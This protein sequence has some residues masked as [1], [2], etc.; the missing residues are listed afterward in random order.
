[1]DSDFRQNDDE[2]LYS[3]AGL[4]E[5]NSGTTTAFPFLYPGNIAIVFRRG[6]LKAGPPLLLLAQK[7]TTD[8]LSFWRKPV[9]I[10][11]QDGEQ[12]PACAGMISMLL[13]SS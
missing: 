11:S 13:P 3:V 10:F 4:I 7:S 12:I 5:K 1:M 6:R 8:S 9:S 2:E